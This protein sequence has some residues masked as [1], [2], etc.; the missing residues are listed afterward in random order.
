MSEFISLSNNMNKDSISKHKTNSPKT[1]VP[2][3]KK[4]H[5]KS[6][7]RVSFGQVSVRHITPFKN[8]NRT[9]TITKRELEQAK[10]EVKMEKIVNKVSKMREE[11]RKKK[12]QEDKKKWDEEI[13]ERKKEYIAF[14]KKQEEQKQEEEKKKDITKN[15]DTIT[16]LKNSGKN[17]TKK[18]F[19]FF[20]DGF[21]GGNPRIYTRKRG[22]NRNTHTHKNKNR[23][24]KHSATETNG[25]TK[26][27]SSK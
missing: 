7:K 15:E 22:K 18:R 8:E 17:N 27:A 14:L 19:S 26:P 4:K 10:H 13:E 21:F 2:I 9:N 1:L 20:R 24:S 16:S 6:N 12:L 25:S 23:V 3:L 11:E 5:N